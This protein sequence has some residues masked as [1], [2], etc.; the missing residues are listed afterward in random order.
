MKNKLVAKKPIQIFTSEIN[1]GDSKNQIQ[2]QALLNGN[3]QGEIKFTGFTIS[4]IKTAVINFVWFNNSESANELIKEATMCA[5]EMGFEIM[6]G[7]DSSHYL[8]NNGFHKISLSSH[9]FYCSELT[10]NAIEKIDFLM[11]NEV[12]FACSGCFAAEGG[13]TPLG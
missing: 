3:K 6:I 1:T 12:S 2:V 9:E 13:C 7:S 10:W 8:E 4:N 11:F 5:W